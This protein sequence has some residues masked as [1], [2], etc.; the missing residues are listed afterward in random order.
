MQFRQ[1]RAEKIDS[2]VVTPTKKFTRKIEE[3]SLTPTTSSSFL[4]AS[5]QASSHYQRVVLIGPGVVLIATGVVLIA[6]GGSVNPQGVKLIAQG[7]GAN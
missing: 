6:P 7:V 1:F 3:T 4:P 2:K 5:L